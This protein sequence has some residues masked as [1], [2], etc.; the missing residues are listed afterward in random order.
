MSSATPTI[1]RPRAPIAWRGARVTAV[2]E[3]N[4]RA[5]SLWL[6][7]PD[8]PGHR[9][10][11]HLDLRL[12]AEDGYQAQRSYS[13][14]SAPEDGGLE[15][16]VERLDDGEVSPYLVDVARPGDEL[17]VRGPVGGFFVW[18]VE[19]PGPLA[20]V[21]GGSGV[22]PL[23]A[24]LRHRHAAG[25]DGEAALL[26]SARSDEDVLFRDELSQLGADVHLTLTRTQPQGWTGY[27]RRVDRALL[28]EVLPA[29]PASPRIF[30]CG[31]TDFVEAVATA[32]VTAGHDPD[33]VRTER[34]GATGG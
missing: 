2:H 32:L 6:E 33:N 22:V 13:I 9:P 4:E 12:T 19:Q 21:A 16:C 20:L 27:A 10:G 5:R 18:T 34:F 31:A 26:L 7:V 11:Q 8:W 30:V 1:E 25:G 28:D 24:M 3:H 14:A 23:V 29:P 15:I 17:E